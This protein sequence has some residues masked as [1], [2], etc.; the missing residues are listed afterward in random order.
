M[1]S[2]KKLRLFAVKII[3]YLTF[4]IFNF[5]GTIQCDFNLVFFTYTDRP[6][7]VYEPLLILTFF[8]DPHHLIAKT[9]FSHSSG[10][11]LFEKLYF[12]EIFSY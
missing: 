5:K 12:L 4:L 3:L 10:E 8:R 9:T 7:P 11:T 6:R 2:I 1:P